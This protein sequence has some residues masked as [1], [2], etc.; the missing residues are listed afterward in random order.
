[1]P[2]AVIIREAKWYHFVWMVQMKAIAYQGVRL[3]WLFS[4]DQAFLPTAI[5][6]TVT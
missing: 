4:P 2:F 1:M 6:S 5:F 3:F